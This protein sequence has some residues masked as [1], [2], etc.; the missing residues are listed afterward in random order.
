MEGFKKINWMATD[1][2]LKLPKVRLHP[3][4]VGNGRPE[5]KQ[6]LLRRVYAALVSHY[7]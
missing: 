4:T 3:C 2:V 1:L 5:P 6:T 7:R